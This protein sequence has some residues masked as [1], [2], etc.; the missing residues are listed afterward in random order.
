MGME[1]G[2]HRRQAVQIA[3]SLPEN[4][5]DA[6]LVLKLTAELLNTFLAKEAAQP[7][8]REAVVLAFPE[9]S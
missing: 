5:E 2:W 4:I 8:D 3:A 6:R 7:L 1:M 9:A